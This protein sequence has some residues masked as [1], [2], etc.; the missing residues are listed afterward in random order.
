VARNHDILVIGASAGGVEALKRIAAGLPRD[1]AAAIMITMHLRGDFHSALAEIISHAGPLL[2]AFANDYQ[3]I[4]HG[5]IYIVPPDQHL[6]LYGDTLRLGHGPRENNARPAVDPLFRSAAVCCDPRCIGLVLT[7]YLNDG[8]SGLNAIK[9]CGGITVV[10]DPKDAKF[11]EMPRNAI[12]VTNADHVA[13]L[14]QIPEL[15]VSLVQ[16]PE[17][18]PGPAPRDIRLEAEI[19]IAGSSGMERAEELGDRSVL[20]CPDCHGVLWE[21]KDGGLTRYRCHIGHAYTEQALEAGLQDDLARAL[22]SALRALDDRIQPLRQMEWQ[23][24]EKNRDLLAEEWADRAKKVEAE[25]E[26]VRR[27]MGRR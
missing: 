19:A 2:A 17:G 6:L 16:A 14:A 22:G 3:R 27:T 5:R 24:R 21:I 13:A 10:Q 9:R 1:L 18:E 23:A 11:P 20:A 26:V 8:S 25:A 4:E 12:R 15:L 7:G